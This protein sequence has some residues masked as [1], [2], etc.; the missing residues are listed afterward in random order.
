[1][2][3][4]TIY[5]GSKCNLNCSYCHREADKTEPVVSEKFLQELEQEKDLHVKF[6]GGEPTLYMGTIKKIVKRLPHAHFSVATNGV[7]LDKYL[8]YFREHEF[9]LCLSYD[10][11]EHDLRGFDPFSKVIN[12]P[13]LGVSCTVY[14]GNTNLTKIYDNFAAKEKI[15]GR[16]LPFYPHI[17]H[18]T[19]DDNAE[20]ALLKEDYDSLIEQIKTF[21]NEFYSYLQI[22]GT[23]LMRYYALYD[24][25]RKRIES[26][27]VYGETYCV[28]RQLSKVDVTGQLYSCQYMRDTKL[29]CWQE[30]TAILDDFPLCKKCEVYHMCGGACVKSKAHDLECYYYRNLYSWF[31]KWYSERKELLKTITEGTSSFSETDKDIFYIYT[32]QSDCTYKKVAIIK[33]YLTDKELIVTYNYND[34]NF[35]EHVILENIPKGESV[36]V[37]FNKSNGKC[38]TIYH[39][40]NFLQANGYNTPNEY[41]VSTNNMMMAQVNAL[42]NGKYFVKLSPHTNS[43]AEI[44]YNGKRILSRN[45]PL[46]E[47]HQLDRHYTFTVIPLNVDVIDNNIVTTW[48][49][50]ISPY[51]PKELYVNYGDNALEIDRDGVVQIAFPY[52]EGESF[53][54]GDKGTK[55]G[56]RQYKMEVINDG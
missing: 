2:K 37:N 25:L 19:N 36:V 52:V 40:K 10:G 11:T 55:Y 6:M 23:P 44:T 46:T 48:C 24:N 41:E 7:L 26:N 56:G 49:I 51:Y 29:S 8:D 13:R 38:S 33:V 4:V 34:D 27:Y 42:S 3:R 14:H 12:Y 50:T 22:T 15:V 53:Y 5:L 43:N 1:M 30:Q 35:V 45:V 32:L 54:W 21:M 31:K 28:N 20:Y 47:L 17:M 39:Y 18:V 9:F 16:R